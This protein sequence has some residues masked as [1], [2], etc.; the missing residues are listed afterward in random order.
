MINNAF[1]L[2]ML[3]GMASVNV[4]PITQQQAQRAVACNEWESGVGHAD[5]A[6]IFSKE[7]GVEVPFNRVTAQLN[8]GAKILVGQYKG[9]RLAE[10]ATSLPEGASI[11]WMLVEIKSLDN[12]GLNTLLILNA[13]VIADVAIVTC[14]TV[15]PSVPQVG[16]KI[17]QLHFY[18]FS[19][20]WSPKGNG[21]NESASR[22]IVGRGVA[23]GHVSPSHPLFCTF[24]VC[25][26]INTNEAPDKIVWVLL[27]ILTSHSYFVVYSTVYF[28]PKI[29]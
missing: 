20:N 15:A 12:I 27:F 22:K 25:I 14:Y 8:P 10:G 23:F 5:T 29:L 19:E 3:V 26:P 7:L 21:D 16:V 2:N 4:Y 1:S 18:Q 17:F 9:P 13:V 24:K 11:Q 6:K 28:L